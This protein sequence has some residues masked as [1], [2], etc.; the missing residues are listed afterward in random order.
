MI[1]FL[2]KKII[3]IVLFY[4]FILFIYFPLS[5]FFPPLFFPFPFPFPLS[6]PFPPFLLPFLFF[7]FISFP[8]LNYNLPIFSDLILYF[9]E[10]EIEPYNNPSFSHSFLKSLPNSIH[11]LIHTS[12]HVKLS[13]LHYVYITPQNDMLNIFWYITTVTFIRNTF[14]H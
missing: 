5:P 6:S 14:C 2:N 12:C 10:K 9:L 11:V 1:F 7:L 4:L 8:F 3:Y 13:S